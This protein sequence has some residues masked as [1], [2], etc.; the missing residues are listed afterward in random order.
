M[1]DSPVGRVLRWDAAEHTPMVPGIRAALA[2]GDQLSAALFT[3]D[4]GAVVPE[5]DHPNEEFGQVVDGSLEL[6]FADRDGGHVV[7]VGAG[8]AFILPGGIRHSA[9][10][11]AGGCTLL[12]CYAPPRV[13][14]APSTGDS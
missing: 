1:P 7:V 11:G 8:E 14:A 6:R 3:L 12:E 9:V 5:H 2:S 10:A 4:A 13:P